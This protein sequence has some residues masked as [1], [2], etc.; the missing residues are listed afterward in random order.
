[1]WVALYKFDEGH[2]GGREFWRRLMPEMGLKQDNGTQGACD[3]QQPWAHTLAH[4]DQS[5]SV[6]GRRPSL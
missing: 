1:M 3:E 5:C 6:S 2:I 4:L